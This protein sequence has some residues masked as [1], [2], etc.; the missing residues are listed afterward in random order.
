MNWVFGGPYLYRADLQ[1]EGYLV[2]ANDD[3]ELVFDLSGNHVGQ[4][5]TAN[6]NVRVQFN[7]NN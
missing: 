2:R 1:P 6:D 4:L 3:V 5:V 7:A